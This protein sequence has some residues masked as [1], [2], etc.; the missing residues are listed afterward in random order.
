MKFL[1][2]D[3]FN[4]PEGPVKILEAT[5]ERLLQIIAF[6]LDERYRKREDDV[7]RW[8]RERHEPLP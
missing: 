5:R 6:L 4:F 7:A 3:V 8:W 2:E 1:P